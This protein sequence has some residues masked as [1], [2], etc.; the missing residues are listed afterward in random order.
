[1]FALRATVR[2]QA[3]VRVQPLLLE[4][5]RRHRSIRIDDHTFLALIPGVGST[6]VTRTIGQL[7]LDVAVDRRESIPLVLAAIEKEIRR[8]HVEQ[9]V[10][11]EWSMPDRLAVQLR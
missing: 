3:D 6:I 2:P 11:I 8:D 1:M 10:S 7:K 9:R 5:L 4:R